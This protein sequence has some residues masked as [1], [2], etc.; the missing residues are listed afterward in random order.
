MYIEGRTLRCYVTEILSIYCLS[1]NA[2]SIYIGL[3]YI[4]CWQIALQELLRIHCLCIVVDDQKCI[5]ASQRTLI[6]VNV[7][8]GFGMRVGAI[9]H[10]AR[11]IVR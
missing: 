3:F 9:F 1:C 7:K 5:A 11:Q 8:D 10:I 6:W 4:R 2:F